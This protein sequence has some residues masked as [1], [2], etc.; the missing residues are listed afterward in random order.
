MS[1]DKSRVVVLG[2]GPA[3]LS[4]A[5]RLIDMG[6]EV[7]LVERR[8]HLGGLGAS[9]KWHDFY[10]DFGPH[11]FHPKPS[12]AM[13]NIVKLFEDKK[14][15]LIFQQRNER[16]LL[17]GK[18]FQ[19]PLK[20]WELAFRLS[21]LR[22]LRLGFDFLMA[23]LIYRYI[24]VP[25]DNFESWCVKRFGKSLYRLCFGN[26]T[27]KVW[28]ISPS[29][30]SPKFARQKIHKLSLRDIIKKIFGGRGEE[31]EN[32]WSDLC[33]T[34][35]GSGQLF[36]IYGEFLVQKKCDI[37]LNTEPT[38][39]EFNGNRLTG[40]KLRSGKAEV[41]LPVDLVVSTIPLPKLADLTAER[42]TDYARYKAGL[43]KFRSLVLVYVEFAQEN[44]SGVHWIYLLD[45]EYVSN[46]FTEQKNMS[47]ATCPK[48]RTVL[49]FEKSC[50]F[51]DDVWNAADEEIFRQ[52][53]KD[54]IEPN[55][56]L[57]ADLVRRYHIVRLRHAYPIYDLSFDRNLRVVL[58][59]LS[60]IDNLYSIGRQGL[61]LQNDQHGSMIMGWEIG[62]YVKPGARISPW[63]WYQS[64]LKRWD[65]D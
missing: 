32:Y 37:R 62:D 47:E 60:K 55:P 28:G 59:S 42:L 56:H 14:D 18:H 34:K 36:D 54:D 4:A 35:L 46:R 26:Y 63:K 40:V 49:C 38:G 31:Q 24:A 53:V 13:D 65:M 39:F 23:S 16:L 27:E 45:K 1:A 12:P 5:H 17:Y 33:Y 20:F 10:L 43:L 7:T 41:V 15:L 3:G 25:D 51:R 2:A 44:A 6:Y 21:P 61:F 50:N 9:F 52:V 58:D 22:T 48:D 19:Y 57:R 29:K 8:D 11:A 30:I 64:I